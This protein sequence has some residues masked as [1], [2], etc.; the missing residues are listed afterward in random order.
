MDWDRTYEHQIQFLTLAFGGP[1]RYSG[2]SGIRAAHANINNGKFPDETHFIAFLEN[3][4]STLKD[5]C[6]PQ[7]DTDEIVSIIL[8]YRNDVLGLDDFPNDEESRSD[9]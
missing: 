8:T 6:I 2:G 9:D 4:I 7:D 5:L 3:L 1:N